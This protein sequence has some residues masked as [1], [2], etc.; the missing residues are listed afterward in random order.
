MD[1]DNQI[2]PDNIEPNKCLSCNA[3]V[4]DNEELCLNCEILRQSMNMLYSLAENYINR[5]NRAHMTEEEKL[6]SYQECGCSDCIQKIADIL[7]EKHEVKDNPTSKDVVEALPEIIATEEHTSKMC[8]ICMEQIQIGEKITKLSCKCGH[9][10]HLKPVD[11]EES[12]ITGW[13]Q[14]QNYCPHCRKKV[15]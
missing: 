13:L 11:S 7:G 4:D 10:Y 15:V 12:C 2:D 3:A 9:F 14:H 8:T 6:L 5:P 1:A